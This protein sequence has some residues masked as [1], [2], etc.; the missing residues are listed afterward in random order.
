MWAVA[1]NSRK[2]TANSP[3]FSKTATRTWSYVTYTAQST[4]LTFYARAIIPE[5]SRAPH[6]R[7]STTLKR[8]RRRRET[9]RRG[10]HES[11]GPARRRA[12]R[13]AH[14]AQ[15]PVPTRVGAGALASLLPPPGPRGRRPWGCSA[16]QLSAMRARWCIRV[17]QNVGKLYIEAAMSDIEWYTS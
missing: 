1:C 3:G 4:R 16:D 8:D 11:A 2:T 7:G 14:M 13:G 10:R 9:S 5:C 12:P 6:M 17:L 15:T